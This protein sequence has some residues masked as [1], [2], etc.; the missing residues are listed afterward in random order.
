MKKRSE[1]YASAALWT[2]LAGVLL[3]AAAAFAWSWVAAAIW[4]GVVAFALA[5]S[6]TSLSKDAKTKE[7]AAQRAPE[8]E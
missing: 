1:I 7:E 6:A 5:S 3:I 8:G 2:F 4:L